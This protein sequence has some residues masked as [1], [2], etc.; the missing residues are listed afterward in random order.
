[1]K[2]L[3]LAL[4]E[5]GKEERVSVIKTFLLLKIENALGIHKSGYNRK[6]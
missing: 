6:E 4:A 3:E 5:Y 1:M 2:I